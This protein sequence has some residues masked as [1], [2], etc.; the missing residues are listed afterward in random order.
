MLTSDGTISSGSRVTSGVTGSYWSSSSMGVRRTTAPG[1]A[2]SSSPSLNWRDVERTGSRGGVR[3]SC[4]SRRGPVTRLPPP[5]SMNAFQAAGFD[6]GQ[7][8]GASPAIRL[9]AISRTR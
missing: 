3:R 6:H 9:I 2:A 5:V 8:A 7:F 1:V 4:A